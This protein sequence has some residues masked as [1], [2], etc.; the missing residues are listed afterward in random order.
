M[1]R[2]EFC[3]IFQNLIFLEHLWATASDWSVSKYMF[4]K[5]YF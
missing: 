1:F 3:E 2:Y 4:I 5:K